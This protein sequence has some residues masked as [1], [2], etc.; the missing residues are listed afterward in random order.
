MLELCGPVIVSTITLIVL[1]VRGP[2]FLFA[3]AFCLRA[4]AG[5]SRASSM[6]GWS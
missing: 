3:L 5:V 6:R 4:G 2:T 1:I